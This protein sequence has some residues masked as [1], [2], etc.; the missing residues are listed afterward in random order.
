MKLKLKISQKLIGHKFNYYQLLLPEKVQN[1][2][3]GEEG[4]F[5]TIHLQTNSFRTSGITDSILD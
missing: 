1:A 4:F 2:L 5:V 3:V